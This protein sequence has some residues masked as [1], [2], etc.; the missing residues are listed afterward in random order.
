MP[1]LVPNLVGFMFNGPFQR[2]IVCL[3]QEGTPEDCAAGSLAFARPKP[4]PLPTALAARLSL[5]KRGSVRYGLCIHTLFFPK[6]SFARPKSNRSVKLG[7]ASS[8]ITA[9]IQSL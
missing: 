7:F 5:Q 3:S 9:S 6:S 8:C 1:V 2:A 4:A